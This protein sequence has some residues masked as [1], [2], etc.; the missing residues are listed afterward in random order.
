MAVGISSSNGFSH[1]RQITGPSRCS[2]VVSASAD[3]L[4]SI[5]LWIISVS[6]KSR[7]RAGG[8]RRSRI[9]LNASGVVVGV[10]SQCDGDGYQFAG[11]VR[12][13]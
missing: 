3:T 10:L 4:T 11:R 12:R 5:H 1:F 7:Y 13:H 9:D 6:S 2:I 8:I